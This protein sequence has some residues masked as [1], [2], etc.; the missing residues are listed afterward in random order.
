MAKEASRPLNTGPS[1]GPRARDIP[2]MVAE[3]LGTVFGYAGGSGH[4]DRIGPYRADT[5]MAVCFLAVILIGG[6][7]VG[8]ATWH[9]DVRGAELQADIQTAAASLITAA[10][11]DAIAQSSLAE[12]GTGTW[13]ALEDPTFVSMANQG[14][15]IGVTAIA[16]YRLPL[17]RDGCSASVVVSSDIRTSTRFGLLAM[18]VEPPKVIDIRRVRP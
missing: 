15:L 6:A 17:G 11:N 7:V 16:S 14:G 9:R 8:F 5:L 12:C 1:S 2:W 3:L 4:R 18:T 13:Q 10:A